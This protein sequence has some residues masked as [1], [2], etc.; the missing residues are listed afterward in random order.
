MRFLK[1]WKND[2]LIAG[3]VCVLVLSIWVSSRAVNQEALPG[4]QTYGGRLPIQTNAALIRM[5]EDLVN[6]RSIVAVEDQAIT[7]LDDSSEMHRY[8]YQHQ[9]LWYDDTPIAVQVRSFCFEYRD[10]YGNRLS[11]GMLRPSDIDQ[12]GYTIRTVSA[13]QDVMGYDRMEIQPGQTIPVQLA[14]Q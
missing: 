1:S 6:A 13:G 3:I 14:Y 8:H 4:I 7:L 5:H 9:S 12:I 10:D 2:A 11:A